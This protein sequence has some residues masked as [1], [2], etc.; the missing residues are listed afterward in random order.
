[1]T[2]LKPTHQ[3]IL[4][5]TAARIFEDAA[6]AFADESRAE[7]EPQGILSEIGAAVDFAGDFAGTLALT[8]PE[9]LATVLAANMLGVEEGDPEATEKPA[10]ALGEIVNMICGNFLPA[11]AGDRAEFRIGAPRSVKASV[12]RRAVSAQVEVGS[13]A[14]CSL[15]IE[16]RLVDIFVFMDGHPARGLAE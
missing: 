15:I 1:M 8:A 4:S 16:D 14:M 12:C 11:V 2:K 10:D 6:F 13:M 3:R 9:E 5:E 7:I